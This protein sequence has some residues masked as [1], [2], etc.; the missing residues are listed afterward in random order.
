MPQLDKD[1]DQVL[2]M[3]SAEAEQVAVTVLLCLAV[4]GAWVYKSDPRGLQ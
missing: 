1:C 4:M 2:G 3:F